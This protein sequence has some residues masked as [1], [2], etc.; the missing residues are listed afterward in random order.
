MMWCCGGLRILRSVICWGWLIW[1]RVWL[2]G[3]LVRMGFVKVGGWVFCDLN[4]GGVIL[5]G[6]GLLLVLCV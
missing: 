6:C 3:K 2:I 1:F 4:L 5:V